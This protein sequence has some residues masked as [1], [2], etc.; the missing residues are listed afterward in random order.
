M[1]GISKKILIQVLASV[2]NKLKPHNKL[3]QML[4]KIK[5]KTQINKNR[6]KP[7]KNNNKSSKNRGRNQLSKN[8]GKIDKY[9]EPQ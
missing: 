2:R 4:T 1:K 9:S 7:N 6:N 8:I 5:N 3:E